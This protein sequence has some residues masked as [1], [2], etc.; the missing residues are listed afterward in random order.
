M[1]NIQDIKR[2]L[3]IA[4][5]GVSSLF[6]EN[7]MPAFI[8]ALEIGCKMIEFDVGISGDNKFIVIHDDT[9]DRTTTGSGKVNETSYD[10]IYELDAGLKLS[11]GKISA[12][13]PLLSDVLDFAYNK[14]F[15]NIEIKSEVYQGN[16]KN[17]FPEHEIAELVEKKGMTNQVIFSSF[18]FRLLSRLRDFSEKLHIGILTSTDE[19]PPIDFA[20]EINAFSWNPSSFNL[21]RK[22]IHN[23]KTKTGK[24]VFPYTVNKSKTATNLIKSGADGFFTDYPQKFHGKFLDDE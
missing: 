16:R 2:P 4:H 21:N 24:F 12:K 6:P 11:N 7:T 3:I 1:M 22:Q 17:N 8:S 15:L 14:I 20:K 18:N 9:L 5:R 10:E 23:F 13:I 19:K